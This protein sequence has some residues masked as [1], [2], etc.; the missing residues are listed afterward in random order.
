MLSLKTDVSVSTVCNKQKNLEEKK[1]FFFGFV[2]A[3]DEKSKIQIRIWSSIRIRHPVYGSIRMIDFD[4]SAK[5]DTTLLPS[6]ST[7]SVGFI[8]IYILPLICRKTK[9]NVPVIKQLSLAPFRAEM[10]V[11][12]YFHAQTSA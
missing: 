7:A 9:V 4:T 1:I 10:T 5:P 2:K 11:C 6:I 3:T 12:R 8:R